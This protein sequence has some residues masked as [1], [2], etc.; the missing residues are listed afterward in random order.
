VSYN[1]CRNRHCPKCGS[2]ARAAWLEARQAELLPVPYF[3]LVFTLPSELATLALSNRR[4]LYDLLFRAATQTLREIAADPR[5]LGARIGGLLV[6]HTWGQNLEHHPHVHGVIPG[7]GLSPDG[8]RWV[9]SRA[10]FFLPVKVLSR[11]FRR[12]FLAGLRALWQR[13]E[14]RLP[15]QLAP[16]ATPAEWQRFQHGL[17]HREWVVYAKP[18]F[19]GP[20]Q[21]LKYLARYTHR[22]AISNDR[23]LRLQDGQ[24]TFSWKNYA[25][26]GQR[27]QM[28]LSGAEFLRRFL[29]HVLPRGFVRIRQFGLWSNGQ[30]TKQ[31]TRCRELLAVKR[32]DEHPVPPSA[33]IPDDQPVDPPRC[34]HCG[35]GNWLVVEQASRPCLPNLL[36]HATLFDSS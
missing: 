2:A 22:V 13:G 4:L 31:L 33:L 26:G 7:G 24:V 30:R 9:A 3:H 14:L 10:N 21:T 1:S 36:G 20:E 18:P 17:A 23:L 5:H 25:A 27:Q 34:P 29:Q 16:L 11:V 15:G 19:G 35:R 28:T 12:K 32:P 8:Q 6:L